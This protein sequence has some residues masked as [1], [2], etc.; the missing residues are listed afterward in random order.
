MIRNWVGSDGT[1]PGGNNLSLEVRGDS[2]RRVKYV[3]SLDKVPNIP[4]EA[5]A[6]LE[7]VAERYVFRANDY[8]LGLIDWNDPD[9]PIKQL[10][11]PRP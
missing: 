1:N 4:P 5:R 2:P 6:A 11:I 10:I 3:R 9:D 8:Y 7:A